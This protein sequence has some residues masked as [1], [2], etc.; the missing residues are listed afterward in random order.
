[1]L[2]Q[3]VVGFE[4]YLDLAADDLLAHQQVNDVLPPGD[5]VKICQV[6]SI[7][8]PSRRA[9]LRELVAANLCGRWR[10]GTPLALSA[11]TPD[12]GVDRAKFDYDGTRAAPT[13]PIF[14]GAIRAAGISCSG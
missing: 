5:E 14:A 2:K 4:N 9:A 13:V 11:D 10:D 3:D 7:A 8:P 12:P 6:F 1:M